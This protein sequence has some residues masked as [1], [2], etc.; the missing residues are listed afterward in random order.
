MAF[1]SQD[2]P[3]LPGDLLVLQHDAGPGAF[4]LCP[5]APG[6][7]GTQTSYFSTNSS[8][9]L[10]HLP[11]QLEMAPAR[12]ACALRLLAATEQLTPLLGTSPN[13]GLPRPGHYE[14]R[15]TVG[16][17]VW[18]NNLTCS[19]DVVSPVAGLRVVHPIPQDGRL[20]LP[21]NS[22]TL[23]LQV[24][25]GTNATATVRWSG[26]NASA[27]FQARCPFADVALVSGCAPEVGSTLFSVLALPGLSVGE[28]VL[29]VLVESSA[30][31]E[32]QSLSV[33]VEEPVQ[34]LHATPNP[35]ARV[36][37]GVLVVSSGSSQGTTQVS[38][39]GF[40]RHLFTLYFPS[41]LS[42]H[43]VP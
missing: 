30:G 18:T 21:T 13:P 19:F 11:T 17:G 37:Q 31:R 5:P 40:R 39:L 28:H 1:R 27:P 25:A 36:L 34:G 23:V 16:N 32:T 22:S 42:L 33:W 14:V 35:E 10:I 7:L 41:Q 3:L 43:G 20:Y 38:I 9:W 4:L 29:E 8:S 24:D 2:S 26:G 6:P 15:A 12:P